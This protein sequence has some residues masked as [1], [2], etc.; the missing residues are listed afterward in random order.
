MESIEQSIYKNWAMLVAKSSVATDELEKS[1]IMIAD[2]DISTFAN[3]KIETV[4]SSVATDELQI[5]ENHCQAERNWL[6]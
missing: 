6:N 2:L 5:T 1:T 4:N 3:V